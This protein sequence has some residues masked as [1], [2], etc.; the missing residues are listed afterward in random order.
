MK[1]RYNPWDVVYKLYKDR[2]TKEQVEE[3]LWCELVELIENYK[4]NTNKKG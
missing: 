1:K 3:M 2:Y 4:L